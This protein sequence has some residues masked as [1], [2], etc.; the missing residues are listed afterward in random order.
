M[1]TERFAT[2]GV[3][4]RVTGDLDLA[5]APRLEQAIAR[6]I[7][8]GHRHFALDL[9]GAT[10]LD[11]ASVGTLVRALAPLRDEPDASVVLGGAT[12]TVERILSLL[13]LDAIFEI[14]EDV[15]R[16]AGVSP[17][18][19]GVEGWR[20][21]A[22]TRGRTVRGSPEGTMQLRGEAPRAGSPGAEDQPERDRAPEREAG[23]HQDQQGER[24]GAAAG[25]L[26][27]VAGAM[28]E[29]APEPRPGVPSASA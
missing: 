9:G 28:E 18:R 7:A 8:C 5:L 4:V 14:V 16:P 15:G 2:H 13:E 3:V 25:V 27:G 6:E 22:E 19:R 17:G 12:G 23:D 24:V 11:C 10:F 21:A 20:W 26:A 1:T 29:G